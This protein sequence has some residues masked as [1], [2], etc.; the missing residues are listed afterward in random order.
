MSGTE[1]EGSSEG[2]EERS[3]GDRDESPEQATGG[4][5]EQGREDEFIRQ[6]ESEELKYNG[7]PYILLRS[8]KYTFMRPFYT[9]RS[10]GTHAQVTCPETHVP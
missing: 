6:V 3:E 10:H 1:P 2:D 9:V 8:S 5:R 7:A 4:T